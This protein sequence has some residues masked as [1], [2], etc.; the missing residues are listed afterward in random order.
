[1]EPPLIVPPEGNLRIHAEHFRKV[2][3]RIEGIKPLA[4]DN[5]KITQ[6][7]NGVRIDATAVSGTGTGTGTGYGEC[8]FVQ[9]GYSDLFRVIY[10]NVCS[11]GQP[12]QIAVFA[13]REGRADEGGFLCEV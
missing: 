2:V 1:M 10:L 8:G 5:I 11:N 9:A 3:R 13:P 7:D 12:D 6:T 4:G